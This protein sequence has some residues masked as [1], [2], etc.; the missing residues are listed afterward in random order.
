M[1][2]APST[3]SPVTFSDD[4]V[5]LMSCC[6]DPNRMNSVLLVFIF[7]Q[8]SSIHDLIITHG[9]LQSTRTTLLILLVMNMSCKRVSDCMVVSTPID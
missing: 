9:T 4:K 6:R 8:F 5:V 3:V 1:K 2:E 7:S